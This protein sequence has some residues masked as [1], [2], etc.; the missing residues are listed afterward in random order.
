[1]PTLTCPGCEKPIT[2]IRETHKRFQVNIVMLDA[3]EELTTESVYPYDDTETTL[4]CP[5]CDH[6]LHFTTGQDNA[7]RD[8]LRGTFDLNA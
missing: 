3:T 1:M 4:E 7:C 5:H 8:I 6:R 2:S